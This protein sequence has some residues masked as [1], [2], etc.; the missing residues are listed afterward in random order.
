MENGV[1]NMHVDIRAERVNA[2]ECLKDA[3]ERGRVLFRGVY[4]SFGGSDVTFISKS[5]SYLTDNNY[6][7]KSVVNNI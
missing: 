4:H 5:L 7:N 1:E 2:R 6:Y 3:R